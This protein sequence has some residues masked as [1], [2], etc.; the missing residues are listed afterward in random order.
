VAVLYLAGVFIVTPPY[1]SH[2]LY[3][4]PLT[5]MCGHH[6]FVTVEDGELMF[7]ITGHNVRYSFGT[8]SVKDGFSIVTSPPS[9]PYRLQFTF[10]GCRMENKNGSWSFHS[11]DYLYPLSLFARYQTRHG[12]H[13]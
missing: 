1:S 13:H 5:C 8:V 12:V 2:G 3:V 9:P 7:Y 10:W 11:R 4:V 6:S